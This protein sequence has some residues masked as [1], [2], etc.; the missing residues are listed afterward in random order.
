MN[1]VQPDVADNTPP[2]LLDTLKGICL[3]AMIFIP[4]A[5]ILYGLP[6]TAFTVFVSLVIPIAIISIIA[7]LVRWVNGGSMNI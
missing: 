7:N 3:I 4:S 6:Q 2:S 5:L 1:F